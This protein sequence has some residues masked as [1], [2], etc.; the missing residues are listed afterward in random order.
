MNTC[1]NNI[2]TNTKI[3]KSPNKMGNI[4]FIGGD[5]E[6]EILIDNAVVQVKSDWETKQAKAANLVMRH[7]MKNLQKRKTN[8]PLTI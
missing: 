2:T 5:L 6:K 8:N 3:T 1:P 7:I 4:C